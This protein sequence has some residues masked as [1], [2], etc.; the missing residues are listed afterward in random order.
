[1]EEAKKVLSNSYAPYSGIHVASAVLTS[2]G[3]VYLGVNVENSSYGL[4]ICAERSALTAMITAGER[5]P[6]AIAIVSDLEEP[7][8]PCGACR[9]FIAE[10]NQDAV[11]IMHSVKS[12]KTVVSK[13]NDIYPNPFRIQIL[14]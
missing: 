8:P 4:T 1:M 7:I 11:I 10:F 5:S 12:G 3:R 6:I 13:L 2:S 9:Q 14:K